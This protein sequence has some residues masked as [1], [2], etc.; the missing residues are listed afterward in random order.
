V[1]R[2]SRLT[3]GVESVASFFKTRL[4]IFVGLTVLVI[5][6]AIV[7]WD[8]Q[9]QFFWIDEGLSV[10]ISAHSP[11]DI[12]RILA[13]FDGSPPL[14]YLMLH[15][16]MK[17][18]GA[19]EV[20]THMLSLA[21]ALATIPA[22]LWAGWS[23]FGKRVGWMFA[24]L[25]ATNPFLTY[26]GRETRQYSVLAFFSLLATACFVHAF[27]YRRR[28]FLAPFALLLVLLLYTHNWA[29][30]YGGAAGLAALVCW[31]FFVDR[32]ERKSF[33]RDAALTF[34]AVAVAYAPW[35]PT[36][37][38]QAKHTG[39]P[40]SIVPGFRDA[41]AQVDA[42]LGDERVL[43]AVLLVGG[44]GLVTI[45]RRWRGT[46]AAAVVTILILFVIPVAIAWSFS[47]FEPSWA[48]RYL[49]VIVGPLLLLAALG[50]ARAGVQGA[51]ALLLVLLF[52]THPLGRVNGAR[53]DTPLAQKSNARAIADSIA[54]ALQPGDIVLSTH[55]EQVPVLHYYLRRPGLRFANEMGLVADPSYV[56]WRD[57]SPK[58]RAA[59]PDKDLAPLVDTLRP[60]GHIALL[61]P[62][63]RLT[64]SDPEWIGL[65]K[66]RSLQWLQA[67]SD[68]PRVKVVVQSGRRKMDA[69][70]TS[71][72]AYVFEKVA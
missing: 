42:V 69:P 50:L 28:Q 54:P 17:A 16:W 21:F 59:T 14:Y 34:G 55:P 23:L 68:D 63:G 58:L 19:G 11:V 33:V 3:V 4:G 71:L 24:L 62:V 1:H 47:Q 56:D 64:R 67:L 10:G 72:Y 27:V 48:T 9:R 31:W 43:V 39:A 61:L 18:F 66:V 53:G 2:S 45:A 44:A 25:A 70:G 20:A 60:G 13:H 22:A 41:I 65:F 46:T 8:G 5:A 37:L 26:Y 36:V 6:S 32:S 30:Y 51:V 29:L 38:F 40:W 57:I 12:V 52:T 7:R 49:A 15:F 35:V